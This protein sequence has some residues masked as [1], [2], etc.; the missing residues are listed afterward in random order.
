MVAYLHTYLPDGA[1]IIRSA[2]ANE[3]VHNGPRE[4]GPRAP[5]RAK[6][7][8]YEERVRQLQESEASLAVLV[9]EVRLAYVNRA[10]CAY[11]R[12]ALRACTELHAEALPT[13]R[14]S[15]CTCTCVCVCCRSRHCG[16]MW[17]LCKMGTRCSPRRR[18]SHMDALTPQ[19]RATLH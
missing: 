15:A 10:A 12:A 19:D 6:Q 7:V 16:P 13:Q 2:L 14:L 1:L 8:K 4:D 3:F 5:K 11:S 18:T 9:A 17:K